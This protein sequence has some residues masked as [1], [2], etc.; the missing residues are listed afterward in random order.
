VSFLLDSDICIAILNG[1]DAAV[2]QHLARQNPADVCVSSIVRAELFFGAYTSAR[3]QVNLARVKAF[4]A[5]LAELQFDHAAAQE[6]GQLRTA[7]QHSGTPIGGNDL[8]IAAQAVAHGH[9]LVTRNVREFK[10]IEGLRI[11]RW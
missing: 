6:Y 5:P 4:L 11:E 2:L 9:V 3:I 1:G 10:R 8:L 7:L